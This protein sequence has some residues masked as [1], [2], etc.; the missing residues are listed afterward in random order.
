[1]ILT[2]ALYLASFG[3][4][5]WKKNMLKV[6]KIYIPPFHYMVAFILIII[7]FPP[8]LLSHSDIK[9]NPEI[10]Y[11]LFFFSLPFKVKNT[12][13]SMRYKSFISDKMWQDEKKP[14]QKFSKGAFGKIRWGSL[15]KKKKKMTCQVICSL[16]L[17][18]NNQWLMLH[19]L[20]LIIIKNNCKESL[21][22]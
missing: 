11:L 8:I 3:D 2:I 18:T 10:P 17:V 9:I 12:F 19:C 4:S 20:R 21:F 15:K 22:F 5:I 6:W 16:S 14:L 1:M 13:R 7:S